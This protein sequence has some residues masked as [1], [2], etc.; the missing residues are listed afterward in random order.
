MILATSKEDNHFIQ[1]IIMTKISNKST[2]LADF[3]LF[4]WFNKQ[5]IT[6]RDHFSKNLEAAGP[7]TEKKKQ[8]CIEKQKYMVLL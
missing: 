5:K 8:T 3:Q 7:I 2:K 6:L 1:A 4:F